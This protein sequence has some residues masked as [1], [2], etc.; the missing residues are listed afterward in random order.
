MVVVAVVSARRLR[1][2]RLSQRPERPLTTEE[3]EIRDHQEIETLEKDALIKNAEL[4]GI[5]MKEKLEEL[6]TKHSLIKEIR[7][8]GL[9]T[10]IQLSEEK[11]VALK[12]A[13]FEKGMLVGSVGASVIRLLPAL[14]I[15]KE[16]IDTFISTLDGILAEM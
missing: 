3:A 8:L 2:E 7:G 14:I 12:N 1:Y 4:M 10:G 5:Y 16:E 9:M 13:L 15:S 11:A 6:I